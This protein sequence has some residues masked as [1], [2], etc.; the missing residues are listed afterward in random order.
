MDSYLLNKFN[1]YSNSGF[2]LLE[3][4]VS[5]LI[6]GI[7]AAI[8]IPSWL[9]FVDTQRLNTAQNEVYLAIRQAQ[10]QA[11]KNKLT[12][13][14]SFREQNNI[15]QWTVH[16]AEVGVF[17][18]NAISNNNTLWH[19]LDQ[20]IHLDKNKYETTLPKQTTKQEWRIMF[21]SQGCPVY[22]V[23]DE[24]T[25]TSFQ[26]LGQITLFSINNSKAKR[27]VYISTIL[28]AMRTGKEHDEPDGNK[29]CY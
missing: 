24:C 6:I 28:G 12:W 3:L 2:T 17:I 5:L 20:N 7:L 14:V 9:A 1:K 18:P 8:S 26:T 10:S 25:Q 13:Q 23:A 27:C 22:Q 11:I 29:Y 19:N 16:Q 15:V 4:L 21:N